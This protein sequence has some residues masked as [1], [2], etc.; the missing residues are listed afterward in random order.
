MKILDKIKGIFKKK[1]KVL[2]L[3]NTIH[4]CSQTR[5]IYFEIGLNTLLACDCDRISHTDKIG[6]QSISYGRKDVI[7][8]I[9]D[10]CTSIPHHYQSKPGKQIFL[11]Y[12]YPDLKS[13]LTMENIEN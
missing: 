1:P 5:M 9:F 11:M 13:L 7:K 6:E 12:L 10:N 2:I 4:E 8:Y 3:E